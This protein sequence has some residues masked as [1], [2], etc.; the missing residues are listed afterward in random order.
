VRDSLEG[1]REVKGDDL[2]VEPI[3]S[4]LMF[5]QLHYIQIELS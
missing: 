2:V 4:G 3:E 5:L 1:L